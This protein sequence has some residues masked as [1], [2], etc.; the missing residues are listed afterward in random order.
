MS[1]PSTPY[2]PYPKSAADASALEQQNASNIDNLNQRMTSLQQL[3]T[4]VTTQGQQLATLQQQVQGL[5]Q[6]QAEA[7]NQLTGGKQLSLTG[8]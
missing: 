1:E 6:Q 3:S 2:Q 7:A 4:T 8:M 5:A